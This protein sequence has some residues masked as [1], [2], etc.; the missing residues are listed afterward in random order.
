[1]P[2]QK[3][4]FPVVT[5][6]ELLKEMPEAS[7]LEL[8]KGIT[9][10]KEGT[11]SALCYFLIKGQVQILKRT[12]KSS[13]ALSI[14]TVKS[15]SFIGEMSLFTGGKRTASVVALTKVK[16]LEVRRDE[17][18]QLLRSERPIATKLALHFVSTIAQRAQGLHQF[19]V[20]QSRDRGRR[21]TP[22]TQVDLRHVLDDVYALWAV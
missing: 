18:F 7:V 9:I 15:G 16:L 19:I 8:D 22:S 13:G 3:F 6:A 21:T 20:K 12:G 17:L 5:A 4:E 10:L 1:M 11:N 14:A 2:V